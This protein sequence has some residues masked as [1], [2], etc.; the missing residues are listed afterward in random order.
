MLSVANILCIFSYYNIY[1]GIWTNI[2]WL[3]RVFIVL[4]TFTP[5][6]ITTNNIFS[7][8]KITFCSLSP[9]L[10]TAFSSL[11]KQDH[12]IVLVPEDERRINVLTIPETYNQPCN[13]E[14]FHDN[15]KHSSFI[16][17]PLRHPTLFNKTFSPIPPKQMFYCTQKS[18]WCGSFQHTFLQG[19]H[20]K[21]CF[22]NILT[23]CTF[24]Y[25]FLY[26]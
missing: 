24:R 10:K 12:V 8:Y 3:L 6:Y 18:L 23:F 9:H 21:L 22:W 19:G 7:G 5:Q 20:T 4:N 11:V 16:N 17:K 1:S 26:F 15:L 14:V 2:V 25:T 13:Q